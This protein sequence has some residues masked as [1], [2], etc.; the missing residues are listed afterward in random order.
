MNLVLD[1]AADV[2]WSSA[3]AVITAEGEQDLA[4]TTEEGWDHVRQG[5][6]SIIETANLL[7]LPGRAIDEGDWQEFSLG[8]VVMGN[9]AMVAAEAK[10]AAALFQA[11]AD[12]YQVCV[13]CH[14]QYDRDIAED[15][16]GAS[17]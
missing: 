12:L 10:D 11:G 17:Q 5:A 3:G 1:P 2:I 6:A 9:K 7:L 16:P 8:L 13:A 4:P 14:Q 15:Q